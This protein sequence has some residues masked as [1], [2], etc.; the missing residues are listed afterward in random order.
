VRIVGYLCVREAKG[1]ACYPI[2]FD[3]VE[4]G[5]AAVNAL[6]AR[7]EPLSHENI[8]AELERQWKAE[9]PQLELP[10]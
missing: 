2:T 7:G 5:Q 8:G 4:K 6:K 10:L 1:R 9:Q 3:D